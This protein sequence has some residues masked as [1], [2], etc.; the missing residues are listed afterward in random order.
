MQTVDVNQAKQFF[1]DL[2][3][4]T[5]SGDEVAITQGG[6]PAAKLVAII[7]PPRKPRRFGS[8]EGLIIADDIDKPLDDFKEYI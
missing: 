3:E 2:I 5:T 8:A 6:Q 1:P 7:K 4:R